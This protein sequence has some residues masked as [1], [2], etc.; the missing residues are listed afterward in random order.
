MVQDFAAPRRWLGS[1][2]LEF[3]TK[4]LSGY[5]NVAYWSPS[6]ARWR[7]LHP[8]GPR[9]SATCR[10]SACHPH[11]GAVQTRLLTP[12]LVHKDQG[13]SPFHYHPEGPVNLGGQHRPDQV[14]HLLDCHF[15]S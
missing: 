12:L 8:K 13:P 14:A 3:S 10:D 5:R 7:P 9:L 2:N 6:G 1:F 11:L 4:D 15:G